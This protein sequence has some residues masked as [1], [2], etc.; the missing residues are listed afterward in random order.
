MKK[1]KC[2]IIAALFMLVT[3]GMG[4]HA[5]GI[6]IDLGGL[7]LNHHVHSTNTNTK[8]E[9][10]NLGG[11]NLGLSVNLFG[12]AAAY[13]TMM[14]S[15]NKSFFAE[16]SNAT[17]LGLSYTF[18]RG[19]GFEFLVG[20]GF[21]ISN[22]QFFQDAGKSVMTYAN[23][24]GGVNVALA[25]MFTNFFGVYIADIYN[26]YKPIN[27]KQSLNIEKGTEGEKNKVTLQYSLTGSNAVVLGVKFRL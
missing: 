2:S 18:N 20:A 14:A 4:V 15:T 22:A 3:A 24:G 6:D 21:A 8:V 11:L 13:V 19:H 10:K 12:N 9:P 17:Q 5:L 7:Y 25:Y 27:Q 26:I 16:S 23:I 1:M